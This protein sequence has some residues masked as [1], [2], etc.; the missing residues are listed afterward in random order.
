MSLRALLLLLLLQAAIITVTVTST[1]TPLLPTVG[2]DETATKL[3]ISRD[4]SPGHQQI[5][6]RDTA[7]ISTIIDSSM[8]SMDSPIS[9]TT[10]LIRETTGASVGLRCSEDAVGV[11]CGI[12]SNSNG[13]GSSGATDS[14]P[15]VRGGDA[16][17]VSEVEP[18]VIVLFMFFGLGTGIIIMQ[19]LSVVGGSTLTSLS[20]GCLI[21]LLCLS[22]YLSASGD[23]LPYTCVIF[24]AGMFMSFANKNTA[25][26][27]IDDY[28]ALHQHVMTVRC[29]LC[30]HHDH[31]PI[32]PSIRYLRRLGDDVDGHRPGHHAVRVP[33]APD[34]RRSHV[35][36]LAPRARCAR[37]S[38]R[39]RL[40]A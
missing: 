16:D 6:H 2:S 11:G 24:V 25:G 36:Q 13:N 34:L 27:E 12:E 20:I 32:H 31:P 22:I 1:A 17:D 3:G 10:R 30:Y 15:S 39:P 33:A 35:A 21:S 18:V 9:L 28:T 38:L 23:P 19:L 37:I 5:V 29:L 14:S 40:T 4:S 8:P 7:E 26:K